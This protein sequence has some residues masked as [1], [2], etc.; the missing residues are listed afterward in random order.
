MDASD[1][2]VY[3]ALV[4]D[5]EFDITLEDN[6]LVVN[7]EAKDYT[8][9]VLREGYVSLIVDGQSTP[10]SVE[11]AGS[12]TLRVMI[13]GRRTEVQVKDERDLAAKVSPDHADKLRR[14]LARLDASSNP[15]DMDL[16]GYRLHPLKSEYEDFWAV[17]VSRNWRVIFQ[18]IGDH[19][20]D[21]DYV[22]Y[23]RTERSDR[24]ADAES[25]S[26]RRGHPE[27]LPRSP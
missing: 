27:R 5:R 3:R 15:S 23:H 6:Q 13:D 21:V 26:S 2:Q 18:F 22:D 10:V 20:T 12:D 11:P 24:Y 19:V 14:T 9:E 4:N 16:P 8:F 1:G 25:P 17:E 7:G